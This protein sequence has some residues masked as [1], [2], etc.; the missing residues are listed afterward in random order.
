MDMNYWGLERWRVMLVIIGGVLGGIATG[1]W[2]ASFLV[3]T[4]VFVAW[5]SY[6]LHQLYRWLER[7]AKA[8]E[9]P[10]SDGVWER[11]NFH[12]NSTKKRSDRR[13]ERMGILLKR[14]QGIITNLPYATVVLT[15]NNEIDWANKLSI[16]LLNIDISKD[17]GQRIEN[18]IRDPKVFEL[19]NKNKQKELEISDLHNKQIKLALQL[20]PIEGDLKLLIARDISE[21]VDVQKMRK[22]FIAN[23]SH[24]LRT[25]LTVIS[26]YLEIIQSND[27]LPEQLIPAVNSASKQSS[28]MKSIIEDLLTLSKLE[29]S[30]LSDSESE[31]IDLSRIIQNICAEESL[32]DENK[33]TIDL[34]QLDESLTLQG[35]QLEIVSVCSN[36]IHNAVRYTPENTNITIIWKKTETGEGLLS[37]SDNGPGIAPE[38][39]NHLTERFYRVDKGRSQETGGTGLGL[40]IVQHI[41]QRHGGMLEIQSILGKGSQFFVYFPKERL[42]VN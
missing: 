19:L 1:Q 17:R 12:I 38:H 23:A 3:A 22:N 32:L 14:F 13:K 31:T 33:H 20:I 5:L 40:A 36:L 26:G 37:V 11:L 27:D 35:S 6:K 8:S 39:L 25:P 24:E 15:T 21:R 2:L 28:R 42:L 41:I 9:I 16:K 18:L 10:E 7:G 34:S 4:L 29:N 30:E